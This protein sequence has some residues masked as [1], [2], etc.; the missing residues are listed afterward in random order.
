MNDM[1]SDDFPLYMSSVIIE[2]TEN[3]EIVVVYEGEGKDIDNVF[4]IGKNNSLQ[5]DISK[6]VE[7][8][9]DTAFQGRDLIEPF[10]I[11]DITFH[12]L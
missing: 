12:F 3:V 8:F 2:E 1:D 5:Q 4:L 10:C 6:Q 9:F 11:M 7:Q